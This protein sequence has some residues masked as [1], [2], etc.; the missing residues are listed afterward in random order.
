MYTVDERPCIFALVESRKQ[1]NSKQEKIEE[2]GEDS[3]NEF[4]SHPTSL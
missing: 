4:V 1:V 3:I 2:I